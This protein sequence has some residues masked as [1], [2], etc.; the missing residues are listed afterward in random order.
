MILNVFFLS[1]ALHH[2]QFRFLYIDAVW[3]GF[4]DFI[5]SGIYCRAF[6]GGLIMTILIVLSLPLFGLLWGAFCG[7]LLNSMFL[8]DGDYHG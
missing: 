6:T 8:I 3:R 5:F 2:D 4:P 1:V 7:F